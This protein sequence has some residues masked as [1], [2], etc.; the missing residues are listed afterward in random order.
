MLKAGHQSKLIHE[1]QSTK[2]SQVKPRNLGADWTAIFALQ[3][4]AH[5]WN[6]H[7]TVWNIGTSLHCEILG[8]IRYF[9]REKSSRV[10]WLILAQC[11]MFKV[12]GVRMHLTGPY[13]S[14]LE[15]HR[16]DNLETTDLFFP[17]SESETSESKI[18]KN[19][20]HTGKRWGLSHS[21]RQR[22]KSKRL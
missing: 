21:W 9:H 16:L 13:L 5:V 3:L 15:E 7:R 22:T 12:S 2:K 4:R 6:T 1:E 11:H 17:V 8:S 14:Q 20:A 10:S 19:M 18:L